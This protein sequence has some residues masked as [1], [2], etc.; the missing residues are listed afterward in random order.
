VHLK[1]YLSRHVMICIRRLIYTCRVVVECDGRVPVI[2]SHSSHTKWRDIALRVHPVW[3]NTNGLL[4]H[5][6]PILRMCHD[7][8]HPH[9]MSPPHCTLVLS[10]DGAHPY[11]RGRDARPLSLLP[12]E[13]LRRWKTTRRVDEDGAGS[14][15]F[16]EE[17]ERVYLHC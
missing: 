5:R 13:R 2:A 17:R 4:I 3:K 10:V 11:E 14:S 8:H 12:Q 15:S 9:L 6:E 16:V 1:F 7:L